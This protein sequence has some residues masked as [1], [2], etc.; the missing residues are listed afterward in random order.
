[1]PDENVIILEAVS[2]ASDLKKLPLLIP[3]RVSASKP[4]PAPSLPA[5][6][7]S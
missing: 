3:S 6:H 7:A 2:A 1:M 5:C 4:V